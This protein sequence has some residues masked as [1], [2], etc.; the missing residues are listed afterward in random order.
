MDDSPPPSQVVLYAAV[1]LDGYLAGPGDSLT[2]LDEVSGAADTYPELIA[3]VRSLVMGRRTYDVV[4]S[5]G[6]WP[7]GSL[8]TIVV[9][10][11]PLGEAPAGV[12]A[13]PGHD[14]PGLVRRTSTHG[15]VWLVG[16]GRL[17]RAFLAAGLL[18][19]IDLTLTPH[20]LG[21]GVPLWG[22]DTQT[23]H[24]QLVSV[25]EVGSGAVRVRYRVRPR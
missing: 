6:E 15:R 19:E 4:R 22:T 9:T 20:V 21:G 23:H 11:R 13:D 7:Y 5:L 17:A 3:S 8:S 14:L 2:F 1:S 25:G 10:S 12:T 16:G 24:L 18:D